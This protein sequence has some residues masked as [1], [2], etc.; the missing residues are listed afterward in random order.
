MFGCLNPLNT[1]FLRRLPKII[2]EIEPLLKKSDSHE[3]TIFD[4]FG[5]FPGLELMYLTTNDH[6]HA[7]GLMFSQGNMKIVVTTG[8]YAPR[9]PPPPFFAGIP[10]WVKYF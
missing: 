2:M 1:P 5:S 6:D 8:M 4:I 3:K 10:I 7:A 9:K